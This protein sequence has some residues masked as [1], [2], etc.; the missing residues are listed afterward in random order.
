MSDVRT[1]VTAALIGLDGFEVLAA[2]DAGGELELLV[3]TTADLAALVARS[4]NLEPSLQVGMR[5]SAM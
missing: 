5:A 2:A 4:L 3:Q 1:L